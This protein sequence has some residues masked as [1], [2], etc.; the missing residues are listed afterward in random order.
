M[1]ENEIT[2]N[3]VTEEV[4]ALQETEE[5]PEVEESESEQVE[6][7]PTTEEQTPEE[8]SKFAEVRR[9]A[10]AK[11]S[12]EAIDKFISDQY[13]ESHGIHTKAEYDKAIA[14]QKK[15][16]LLEQLKDGESDPNEVYNKLKENDP[17]YQSMKEARID[18]LVKSQIE[19]L[20]SEL[21]GLDIDTVIN[22]I[23]DIAKL[24]NSDEIKSYIDIGNTLKDAYFLA[25][26]KSIIQNDR[27]KIQQKTIK[28][29][30][31]NGDAAVGELSDTG[32][33]ASLFTEEQVDGMSQAE[34]NENL[35]LILKSMKSW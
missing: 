24:D 8:N 21:K 26:R 1:L 19:E 23:D 28:Q 34:V 35:D 32:E 16:E 4:V 13:G 14:E 15:V 25:N 22:S 11:A 31:A 29:I 10:E 27:T 9:K 33:K 5:A 20:N 17:E 18:S 12:K 3:A 6:V 7:A 2:E 30:S